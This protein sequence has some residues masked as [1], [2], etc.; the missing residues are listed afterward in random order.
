MRSFSLTLIFL[1]MTVTSSAQDFSWNGFINRVADAQVSGDR[2]ALIA[3]AEARQSNPAEPAE[4]NAY[5]RA[6]LNYRAAYLSGEEEPDKEKLEACADTGEL[7]ID[8]GEESGESH[9]LLG[10]CF[11]Q[12]AGTGMMAGMRYGSK[13]QAMLDEALM[14]ASDNPRVLLA[15]GIN[16]LYTPAQYG[17]DIDRAARRLEEARR[18]LTQGGDTD[19]AAWHPS[20]GTMDVHAHLAIALA[21]LDRLED[22]LEVLHEAEEAGLESPWLTSIRKRLETAQSS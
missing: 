17:G 19:D 13:A 2:D 4:W 14:I 18:S 7:A 15:A 9:A 16:D 5:W 10:L 22:A 12:L 8:R 1:F 21:R 11:G 20:W 6:Y 3:L